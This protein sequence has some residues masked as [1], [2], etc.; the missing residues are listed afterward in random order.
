M[1]GTCDICTAKNVELAHGYVSGIETFYCAEG[2]TP[3][4]DLNGQKMTLDDVL[5]RLRESCERIGS[6]KAW[7]AKAGVS[8]AYLSDVLSK[9]RDPGPSILEP[10]GIHGETIY[11]LTEMAPRN[12]RN[13]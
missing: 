8:E 12:I 6:Q 7:A 10:L 9:R 2:C 5:R 13:Q 4:T 1:I 11:R 3:G